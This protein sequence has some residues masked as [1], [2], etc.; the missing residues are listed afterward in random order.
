[1]NESLI[2]IGA[3]TAGLSAGCYAAAAGL[4]TT[5]LEMG[6]VPGGLCASWRRG[7]FR[8]EGSA[9]GLAGT[10]PAAPVYRLWRDLGIVDYCP[11]YDPENFGAVRLSDGRTVTVHTNIDAL[12]EEFLA[13]FPRDAASVRSF[14]RALRSCLTVDIPFPS[15]PRAPDGQN[16]G[17]RLRSAMAAAMAASS[18]AARALPALLT[19]GPRTLG[20]VLKGLSDP[21]CAEAFSNL[22]HFGGSE[23]PLLTVLL[24]LAYAH[25][26][27]T[28]IPVNGWLSFA[29]AMERRFTESGGTL[30]YRSKAV[31]LEREGNRVRG[32]RLADGEV[33]EADLVLSAADG[34][35][36]RSALL[37]E[38]DERLDRD[39]RAER[40][41]D[42]PVQVNLGVS[43]PWPYPGGPVTFQL[44]DA[45]VAAGRP[46]GRITV[47]PGRI[48]SDCAP[49]GKTALMVFLESGYPFWKALA[50]DRGRYESEKRRCAETVVAAISR[51]VPGFPETVE[52]VDVSTPLT[53]EAYTGNR[54]GCMQGPRPDRRMIAA[55][56]RGR[57]RYAHPRLAG[58]YRAG[59]WAEPWG[60]IT[61]A[62][63]S[64]RSAVLELL[65][66]L[67]P[68]PRP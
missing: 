17:E 2:I 46:Q 39:Y 48:G 10:G 27:M 26:R 57:P 21:L 40:L 28:G 60:G 47:H 44:P 52:V 23:A 67:R 64:G 9:A 1:M 41:S 62:A 8:F 29:R 4:R 7:G 24:P 34:Y 65:A 56:L 22:V 33:L 13:A 37:G 15:P 59:Q 66:D 36:T 16:A 11:L 68:R 12:E 14:A 50:G 6:A 43:G 30:R 54:W 5:I 18:A 58:F 3:G 45:P 25:R 32:V 38:G 53:R 20:S 35:F 31:G 55:L 51:T 63:L 19:Y 49:P 42:Q 61:T